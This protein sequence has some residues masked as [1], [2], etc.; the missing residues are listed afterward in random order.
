M[1]LVSGIA[2]MPA[3]RNEGVQP[4]LA[5]K[6]AAANEGGKFYR[7][8][9]NKRVKLG[10]MVVYHVFQAFLADC[11]VQHCHDSQH[12]F[13]HYVVEIK[14]SM[15]MQKCFNVISWLCFEL[16]W[17]SGDINQGDS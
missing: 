11:K 17:S 8:H 6:P 12:F 7:K 9:E 16:N 1:R 3:Y 10:S 2:G 4:L 5:G 14:Y 15:A 13:I